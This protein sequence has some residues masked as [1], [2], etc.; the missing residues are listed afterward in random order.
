MPKTGSCMC[1]AVSFTVTQDLSRTNA[2]HCIMCRKWSGGVYFG[3]TVAAD[4]IDFVGMDNVS[5]YPS[6]AWAERGFCTTCGSSLFYRVTAT[7]P[8]HGEYHIGLGTLDDPSGITF[9]T[10]YFIDLKPGNYRFGGDDRTQMTESQ[11]L[12]FFASVV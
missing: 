5:I 3:V 2:C 7:G 12:E 8:M 4:G 9:D 1:G 6:S 11:V 10:E